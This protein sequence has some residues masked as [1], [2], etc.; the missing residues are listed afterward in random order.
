[1][2]AEGSHCFGLLHVHVQKNKVAGFRNL[3]CGVLEKCPSVLCPAIRIATNAKLLCVD[4]TW[5]RL[6][7]HGCRYGNVRAARSLPGFVTMGVV[8]PYVM[9]IETT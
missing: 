9:N 3:G 5:K 7:F 4:A 1:M 8:A 6:T 2:A